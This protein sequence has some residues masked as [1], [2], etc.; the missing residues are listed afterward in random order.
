MPIPIPKIIG[1]ISTEKLYRFL[2]K[3]CRKAHIYLVDRIYQL[4][5]MPEIERF[6]KEDKTNLIKYIPEYRDCD[7]FSF[8]LMGQFSI[9]E[10]SGLAFGIAFSRVH[11]FNLFFDGKDVYIIE[12]QSDKILTLDEAKKIKAGPKKEISP[13]WPVLFIL[14]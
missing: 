3:K 6:L 7:D 8:R 12:P 4:I 1:E 2:K 13:Y 10:W 14:M 9:P 11:A 5:E